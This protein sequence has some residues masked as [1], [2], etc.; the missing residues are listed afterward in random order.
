[1][2]PRSL[3]LAS[4]FGA[5]VALACDRLPVQQPHEVNGQVFYTKLEE[6]GIGERFFNGLVRDCQGGASATDEVREKALLQVPSR[7]DCKRDAFVSEL[8]VDG[9]FR[10]DACGETWRVRCTRETESPA[11]SGGV[12]SCVVSCRAEDHFVPSK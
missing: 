3:I 6:P 2:A 7:G 9:V 10:I 1:M 11:P 4:M 12:A 5:A 8:V